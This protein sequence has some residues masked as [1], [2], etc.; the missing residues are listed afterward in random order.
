MVHVIT[1]KDGNVEAFIRHAEDVILVRLALR[2]V[3][4]EGGEGAEPFKDRFEE[5]YGRLDDELEVVREGVRSGRDRP[6]WTASGRR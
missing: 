2:R 4:S 6:G 1:P 3:A 5:I